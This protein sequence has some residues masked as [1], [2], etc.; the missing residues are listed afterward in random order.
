MVWSVC[1]LARSPGSTTI[2]P[3]QTTRVLPEDKAVGFDVPAGQAHLITVPWFV[4]P[5][6][7]KN[8]VSGRSIDSLCGDCVGGLM[9]RSCSLRPLLLACVLPACCLCSARLGGWP[10]L[11][12]SSVS[13]QCCSASFGFARAM[14]VAQ[15]TITGPR[16]DCSETVF[17][18]QHNCKY[19]V[20]GFVG[21]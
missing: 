10:S 11:T 6:R 15:L 8:A 3:S 9:A 2:I 4:A 18:V 21:H 7:F 1:F 13:P 14:P 12:A 19:Q 5:V 20:P 16:A 17:A